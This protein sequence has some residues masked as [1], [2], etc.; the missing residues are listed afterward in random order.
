MLAIKSA[1]LR[2]KVIKHNLGIAAFTMPTNVYLALYTSDPTIN[3]TGTEVSGGSYARQQLSWG[4]ESGGT[5]ASNTSETIPVPASTV[6]HWGIRDALTG[7]NLL[8]FGAFDIP[9]INSGAS[10]IPINSGDIQLSEK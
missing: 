5:V 2:S 3:D 6:T 7:G 10:T 1:Y 9:I 8:Y 4:S